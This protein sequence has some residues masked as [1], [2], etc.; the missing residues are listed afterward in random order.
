MCANHP[1]LPGSC[2]NLLK[3]GLDHVLPP[4]RGEP[5]KT[6][7][8]HSQGYRTQVIHSTCA[9]RPK[10]EHIFFFS[11]IVSVQ[12]TNL[13]IFYQMEKKIFFSTCSKLT[14]CHLTPFFKPGRTCSNSLEKPLRAVDSNVKINE[15]HGGIISA[16][17]NRL[18]QSQSTHVLCFLL[19]KEK[20]KREEGEREREEG[21]RKEGRRKCV[22][23]GGEV[24]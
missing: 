6:G 8:L 1:G 22:W 14:L 10:A 13:I 12:L 3:V 7:W 5:A 21:R 9:T 20:T 23:G 16:R 15:P 4:W 24:N 17:K 19:S 2:H 11:I 18:G